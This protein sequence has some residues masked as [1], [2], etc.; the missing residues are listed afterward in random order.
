MLRCWKC[1]FLFDIVSNC[2]QS[3]K[4]RCDS[5]KHDALSSRK[6][7]RGVPRHNKKHHLNSNTIPHTSRGQK[8][9][10]PIRIEIKNPR[11]MIQ[12][13]ELMT[14]L[15]MCTCIPSFTKWWNKNN[16][17]HKTQPEVN[18]SILTAS[19]LCL[20][21]CDSINLWLWGAKPKPK[22]GETQPNAFIWTC[23]RIFTLRIN[24]T[25]IHDW[26]LDMEKPW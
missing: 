21:C 26:A 8:I 16:V 4:L 3:D 6:T 5:S 2:N 17:F 10:R 7:V 15:Q 23:F 25:R 9:K 12:S 18:L 19:N 14:H 24:V 13:S 1:G 20:F 22:S 11:F